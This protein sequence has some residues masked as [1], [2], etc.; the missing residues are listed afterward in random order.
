VSKSD[1]IIVSACLVGEKCRYDGKSKPNAKIIKLAK[2]N[3]AIP[4]CPEVLGGLPTPRARAEI[5]S[6]D[7]VSVL[8]GK[9]RIINSSGEDVT[10]EYI[11]GAYEVLEIVRKEN[12]TRA[13]LKSKSPSCGVTIVNKFGQSVSG[14]GVTAALLKKNGIILEEK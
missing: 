7:G 3:K 14:M 11:K 4:V 2:E 6:G 12:V 1:K 10:E 8:K 13:I 9:S 5:E